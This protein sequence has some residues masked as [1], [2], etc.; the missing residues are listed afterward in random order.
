MAN[1]LRDL[2]QEAAAARKVATGEEA[3]EM[4]PLSKSG[5]MGV[6]QRLRL[7]TLKAAAADRAEERARGIATRCRCKWLAEGERCTGYF[8]R[9]E[10]A[11]RA[12]LGDLGVIDAHGKTLTSRVKIAR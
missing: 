11:R 5:P 3:R 8:L 1:T 7:A 9:L 10:K 4:E 6:D 2:A 12:P